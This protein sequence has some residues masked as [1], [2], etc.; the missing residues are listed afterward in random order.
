MK[1][2]LLQWICCPGCHSPLTLHSAQSEEEEVIEGSLACLQ[3]GQVYPVRKGVPWFEKFGNPTVES[4][5]RDHF[6]TLWT[7]YSGEPEPV[8]AKEHVD[9][10]EEALQ[11]K[12]PQGRAGL[13]AGSGDGRDTFCMAQRNPHLDLI[14][15]EISEG[16]NHTF[17]RCKGLSNVH[18]IGGSVLRL[19]LKSGVLDFAYSYGVLHHTLDPHKGFAEM[20]RVLGP[21]GSVA[22]Y[23]YE[24]HA[25]N[26]WKR[27]ALKGVRG[28]RKV[29]VK[30]GPKQLWALC[31]L[32]SPFVW[33]FF[34]VPS[35][36][37]RL[38]PVWASKADAIPFNF[39]QGPLS[40]RGDLY[41]RF[42]AKIEYRLS[43]QG[44]EQW[45]SG[46]SCV[47]VTVCHMPDVAGWACWGRKAESR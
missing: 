24:D 8:A 42:G 46:Q 14:S 10:L 45:Y 32:L 12:I 18:V 39:G 34:T 29:S 21:K 37:L 38:V 5:S 16:A 33:F 17:S 27:W 3:C 28:L 41:D 2:K 7:E 1:H 13:D 4:R 9:R 20:C 23:L 19:P 43:R 35:K 47:E 15:L 36:I 40:L 6:G 11:R 22:V 30:L 44:I 25:E 31:T 26:R